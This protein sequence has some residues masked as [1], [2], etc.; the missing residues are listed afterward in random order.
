MATTYSDLLRL[1]KQG[2]GDNA[3]TWGVV[4]NDNVFEM[5][6]DAIA[7]YVTVPMAGT[8][9]YTLSTANGS[10]DEA[11]RAIIKFTGIMTVNRNVVLPA[12]SKIYFVHNVTTGGYTITLKVG[13][14]ATVALA[15]GE[16][17]IVYC[18]GTDVVN[19]TNFTALLSGNNTYSGTNT[20]SASNTFSADQN[21]TGIR[22]IGAG[23]IIIKNSAGTTVATIGA[24][25]GTLASFAGNVSALAMDWAK[26]ADL[27]SASTVNIGAASG[28][29]VHITGTTTI[30]AFDT[31]AAGITRIVRFAGA[32]TL[33]HNAT[34]L[35]LPTAAN[36]TTATN[37][38][39]IFVSEGSGNWRCI[40]Y[41]Y[42]DGRPLRTLNS[43]VNVG[44]SNGAGS[45]NTAIRRFSSTI[46]SAGTDITYADSATL[47]ATF[48]INTT[49]VY[50]ISYTDSF[51]APAGLAITKN[52]STL[53]AS[54]ASLAADQQLIET[55]TPFANF[56]SNCSVTVSLVAGDVIRAHLDANN[57]NGASPAQTRFVII[58]IA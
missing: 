45:T 38:T 7:G 35:I 22:A 36:I 1:A 56:R 57:T 6:E 54:Y 14:G 40:S 27:A 16:K 24:S 32:L 8:G 46:N 30:T 49:G 42:A 13:A 23:G 50:S 29:Y 15:S 47:G 39:A 3:N 17:L 25:A 2:T 9:D 28:N 33:T 52:A 51:N 41:V 26:A 43:Y 44:T 34:S 11:R 31:V 48:T 4:L 10:T 55:A 18:D 58:R 21:M 12:S 19:M 20:F 5:L 37:D 53:N